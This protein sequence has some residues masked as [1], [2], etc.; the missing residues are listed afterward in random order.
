M[1][2]RLPLTLILCLLRDPLDLILASVATCAIFKLTHLFR[3]TGVSFI[4]DKALINK[5]N[6]IT[7]LNKFE[8][9]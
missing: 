5:V 9:S 2:S 1:L 4:E 6:P 8:A 3:H 7:N